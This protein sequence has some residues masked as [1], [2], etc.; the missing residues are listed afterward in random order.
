LVYCPS[1][2]RSLGRLKAISATEIAIDSLIDNAEIL[3][4]PASVQTSAWF[5]RC[6]WFFAPGVTKGNFYEV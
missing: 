1:K 6:K 2:G 4:K 3:A 5:K